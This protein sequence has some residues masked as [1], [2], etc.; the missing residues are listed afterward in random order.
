MLGEAKGCQCDHDTTGLL[1]LFAY[2]AAI[3]VIDQ[4]VTFAG[5]GTTSL[6]EFKGLFDKTV[7]PLRRIG[8]NFGTKAL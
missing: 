4:L 7:I 2:W 1:V 5:R 3:N 8:G 6:R